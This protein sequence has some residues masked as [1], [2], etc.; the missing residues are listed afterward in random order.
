MKKWRRIYSK[1]YPGVTKEAVWNAWRNIDQWP[2][3]HGDLEYCKLEGEFKVG[4]HFYLKPQKMRR[5]KI[6]LIAVEEGKKFRDCTRFPGARMIDT[7]EMEETAEGLKLTNI[8]TMEGPLSWL[9]IKLVGQY[10]AETI[11]E[12]MDSLVDMI[13]RQ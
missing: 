3:W 8:I 12:E 1:T 11:P 2:E 7:H 4:S 10:V 13:Q 5:V 9:W 6:E